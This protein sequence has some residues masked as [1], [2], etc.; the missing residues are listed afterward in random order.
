M[1]MNGFF[2]I[3]HAITSTFTVS[4][5]IEM[6]Y[7]SRELFSVSRSLWTR[8][9]RLLSAAACFWDCGFES[10][11]EPGRLFLLNVVSFQVEI[12]ATGQF[13]V[14]RSRSE[15]GVSEYDRGE[16]S[17]WWPWST[18]VCCFMKKKSF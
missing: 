13:L 3:N 5:K 10:L 7:Y 16:T 14:Q 9:L 1:L 12:S 18:K 8:R 17:M 2:L 4:Y 15:C 11:L 6:C